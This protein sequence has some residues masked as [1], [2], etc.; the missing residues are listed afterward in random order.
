MPRNANLYNTGG[1]LRGPAAIFGHERRS[2][3]S[4]LSLHQDAPLVQDNAFNHDN[5]F[6]SS[7]SGLR[8][9]NLVLICV[10]TPD[11]IPSSKLT[12]AG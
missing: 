6:I 11:S 12:S 3:A 8:Y 5:A 4:V 7:L 9:V 2:L 1:L 10:F